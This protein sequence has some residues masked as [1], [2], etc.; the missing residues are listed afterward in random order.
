[1]VEPAQLEFKYHGKYC[2]PNYGDPTGQTPAVDELDEICKLHDLAYDTPDADLAEADLE[3]SLAAFKYD[4]AFS[5]WFYIQSLLRKFGIMPRKNEQ[6]K[7][8][9]PKSTPRNP[10]KVPKELKRAIT[11]GA[12]AL[13][14]AGGNSSG[15]RAARNSS[16]SRLGNYGVNT[17][18]SRLPRGHF[19]WQG[20]GD[21]LVVRGCDYLDEIPAAGA[22][23]IRGTDVY[24]WEVSPQNIT[25]SRLQLLCAMYEKY[26][27]KKVA[28]HFSSAENTAIKGAYIHGIIPDPKD[29]QLSGRDLL[30][31]MVSLPGHAIAKLMDSTA[32]RLPP[33]DGVPFLFV[34]PDGSDERLRSQGTYHWAA[35]TDCQGESD[36]SSYGS[37]EV[38]Y[39][40]EFNGVS[41]R[42]TLQKDV[43]L[44]AKSSTYT[45]GVW[46]NTLFYPT[47][48]DNF[49]Q[50][51]TDGDQLETLLR[52]GYTYRAVDLSKMGFRIGDHLRITAHAGVNMG[53]PGT[54]SWST[55][56]NGV[57]VLN[58]KNVS[59]AVASSAYAT[60][61]AELEVQLDRGAWISFQGTASLAISSFITTP[62][63]PY[64]M[65]SRVFNGDPIP[66]PITSKD[67]LITTQI[68]MLMNKV[69]ELEAQ[70]VRP[71]F[72]V[73][74][75]NNDR[76]RILSPEPHGNPTRRTGGYGYAV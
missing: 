75:N 40:I 45:P 29:E 12:R 28:V 18:L 38:E 2:G 48:G 24:T 60:Y 7:G 34:D 6:K 69:D 20:S 25:N 30:N 56:V 55:A 53:A 8:G 67:P 43:L 74:D 57:A 9:K 71:D 3:A 31:Q 54:L 59:E 66:T 44:Q 76:P 64:V 22:G 47:D 65:I 23:L 27:F 21:K 51:E 39:E 13:A 37:L 5:Y 33:R 58:S 32:A 52:P 50:I 10:V 11:N 1:M 16:R 46:A 26:K 41:V 72:V 63:R 62:S 19:R 35:Y 15:P 17:P 73:V 36:I 42:G 4:P 14:A 68:L 61:I 70:L 49:E